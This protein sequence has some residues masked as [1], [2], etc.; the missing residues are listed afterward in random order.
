MCNISLWPASGRQPL[1]SHG[2]SSISLVSDLLGW[3]ES[4]SAGYTTIYASNI[5]TSQNTLVQFHIWKDSSINRKKN[6]CFSGS[7]MKEVLL[8]ITFHFGM[9][10]FKY[11]WTYNLPKWHERNF[12]RC[13]R[14]G[15]IVWNTSPHR[16]MEPTIMWCT[17]WMGLEPG[18]SLLHTQQAEC[19]HRYVFTI[20]ENR[21]FHHCTPHKYLVSA[22]LVLKFDILFKMEKNP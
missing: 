4:S 13:R 7:I 18:Y 20:S 10:L 22:D 11:A 21:V 17:S 5:R 15:A 16:G 1:L 8:V 14:I 3:N 6:S 12:R 2:C 9:Q 19:V